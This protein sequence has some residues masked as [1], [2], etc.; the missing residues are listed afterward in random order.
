MYSLK[1]KGSCGARSMLQKVIETRRGSHDPRPIFFALKITA[2]SII[3]TQFRCFLLDARAHA[4][5]QFRRADRRSA[6]DLVMQMGLS[7]I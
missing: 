1:F 5:S 3:T 4:A 2:F 7:W 6:Q